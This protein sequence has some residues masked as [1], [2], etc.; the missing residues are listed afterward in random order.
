VLLFYAGQMSKD[1]LKLGDQKNVL[2]PEI[3]RAVSL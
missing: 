1:L 2:S 3:I